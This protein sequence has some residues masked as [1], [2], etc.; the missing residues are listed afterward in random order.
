ME[1]PLETTQEKT[2]PKT[3]MSGAHAV[4]N[5]MIKQGVNTVFGYP[6]GAIMPVYDALYDYKDRIKH[7][8]TRHEQGAIHAAQGYAR[9]T[10]KAGVVFATSGPGATNLVTGLA[11]AYMDSTPLVCITGQV[12]SS[13]LGTDAFQEADVMGTT[14]MVTKWNYLVRDASEIPEVIAKAFYVAESGRP[15][16]VVIDIAKDTQ[17]SE[18]DFTYIKKEP[19]K[20]VVK[21]ISI[22][23]LAL[24]KAVDLINKAQKPMLIFGHGVVIAEAQKQ[25]KDFVEK[26]GIPAAWTILGLNGLPGKHPLNAGMMGMHG[27]YAPNKLTAE[28]DVLIGVGLRFDDRVTGNVATFAQQAKIIHIDIDPS[29]INKIIKA[30]IGLVGDAAGV[31]SQLTELVAPKDNSDWISEFQKLEEI[32]VNKVIEAEMF[33]D[34]G[35]ITMAEVMHH[36]NEITGGDYIAITDVGQQQMVACRY[37]KFSEKGRLLTSGGLG[38]MGFGLPGGIG[39]AIAEQNLPVIAIVGDGGFQMTIQEL[40]TLMQYKIPL[41]VLVLNN[42]F[43][44]MVRQWQEMFFDKRYSFTE[45]QNPDFTGI[46]TCYGLDSNRIEKREALNKHLKQMIDCEKPYVLEVVVGKENNVFPMVEAGASVSD[47]RL[48]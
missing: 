25:L 40:G 30:D 44:G 38:T 43:L 9:I 6:G 37:C 10:G 46:A 27:N 39:A 23:N 20:S 4:M 2:E 48:E 15:G 13:L 36:L 33:P 17:F 7:V 16:P 32:E 12:N 26:T 34:S 11:D 35:E 29:E 41:K 14:L 42:S 28:C 24:S 8:L 5:C 19:Q 31:L 47:I 1:S 3:K 22:D 45:M 21:D 18:V